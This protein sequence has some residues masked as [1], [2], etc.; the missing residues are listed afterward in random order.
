MRLTKLTDEQTPQPLAQLLVEAGIAVDASSIPDVAVTSLV[1]DSRLVTPGSCF[2]AVRGCDEDGHRFIDVAVRSGAVAVVVEDERYNAGDVTTICVQDSRLALAN[3]A[4]AF[5]QLK[6]TDQSFP[7]VGITGTNGKTTV[8]WMLRAILLAAHRRPVTFGTIGYDL[9][10]EHIKA[11]LT[12]PGALALCDLLSQSRTKGADVAVMEVS[13]HALQQ[14]RTDGLSF[15]IGAFT[16]LSGDHLDF[17]G[18]MSQYANAKKRLF[19]QLSAGAT[20][21]INADDPYAAMMV[22]DCAADVVRIGL[23]AK[24]A[25]VRATIDRMTS[26]GSRFMLHGRNFEVVVDV[27]LLGEHN[28]YNAMLAGAM[29]ESLGVEGALIA[30]GLS[31]IPMIP[32]R[33]QRIEPDGH[34]FSVLV[35]Y[36]HTDD[37]LRHV[38]RAVKPLTKNRLICVF[39]CGGDRDRS[40][41]PRMAAVAAESADHVIVTSDNPRHEAPLD[42]ICDVLTGFD[43][44]ARQ[45]VSVEPDRRLAIESAITMAEE[46]DTVLIAGKGHEDY[47]LVGDQVLTF[48]DAAVA[49]ACLA[50]IKTPVTEEVT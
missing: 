42:I 41:R 9:I 5:Y 34:P 19:D 43:D 11:T 31:G 18:D 37:A 14:R 38:L 49:R 13:S 40:K 29:A 17:H 25:D 10:G 15:Q 46:G 50:S 47:Q 4:A 3:L 6:H 24:D 48:D 33:L 32:G 30:H 28:V 2:V 22:K 16:N 27:S 12:T 45:R 23:H 26:S 39:G 20:A 1:D 35:D 44:V 21:V 7:L 8:A 36:A